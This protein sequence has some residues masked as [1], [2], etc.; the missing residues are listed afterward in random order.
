M[1]LFVT[2]VSE[3]DLVLSLVRDY[4][5]GLGCPVTAA[6]SDRSVRIEVPD[7][8]HSFLELLT[9]V[10][11][12]TAK[13]GITVAEPTVRVTYRHPSVTSEVALTLRIDEFRI[14]AV[15]RVGA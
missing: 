15:A 7:D 10:A 1:T 14:D 2:L 12:S 8:D 4:A 5:R 6:S 13:A 9:H 3:S 11:L